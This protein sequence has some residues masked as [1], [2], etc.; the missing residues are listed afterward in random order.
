MP[1]HL[2]PISRRQFWPARQ[3]PGR[4]CCCPGPRLAAQPPVDPN[5]WTLFSDIHIWENRHRAQFGVKPAENFI[6]ARGEVFAQHS[7]PA[8]L[9]VTGDCA[10]RYGNPGDYALLLNL[11]K[12]IRRAG[13][14][15]HLILGN[16]DQR[17][18]F[19]KA[20]AP[21]LPGAAPSP[22]DGKLVSVLETPLANWFLLDSLD[23]TA[24]TAGEL[25]K[26]QLDWLAKRAGRPA[27]KA[28]DRHG[29]PLL[30]FPR[31]ARGQRRAVGGLDAA[32]AGEGVRVRPQPHVAAMDLARHPPDQLARRGLGLRSRAAARLGGH[33][34][35]GD[36]GDAHAQL[37]GQ[38]TPEER[39][40][41]GVEVADDGAGSHFVRETPTRCKYVSSRL[42]MIFRWAGAAS[43]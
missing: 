43:S 16:H 36:G 19:S 32:A 24:V 17:E 35:D 28:G 41:S 25:G 27:G 40:A 1:I 14:P 11:A 2:P 22:V 33:D 30:V 29:A 4:R 9:F 37:A 6:Q 20:I 15:L 12:P 42:R 5:R 26:A 10:F 39:R 23:K 8:G 31:R 34:A 3:P 13:V 18:N 21:T 38:E 7:R